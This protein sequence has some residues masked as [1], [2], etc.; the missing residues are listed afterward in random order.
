[1]GHNLHISFGRRLIYSLILVLWSA[2]RC[3]NHVLI[4]AKTFVCVIDSS[5][6]SQANAPN[7]QPTGHAKLDEERRI[8]GLIESSR[9]ELGWAIEEAEI[10]DEKLC[11]GL[12]KERK[13][14]HAHEFGELDHTVAL[15][16]YNSLYLASPSVRMSN[17]LASQL[18]SQ[19]EWQASWKPQ[20]MNELLA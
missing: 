7:G 19:C 15:Y 12:N 2:H 13:R 3:C 10:G 9:V 20:A 1:M 4:W 6:W 18:A 16:S 17:W 5:S 8:W 14:P 11:V